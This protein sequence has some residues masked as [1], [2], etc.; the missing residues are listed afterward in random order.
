MRPG[1]AWCW[2]VLLL[3]PGAARRGLA[4]QTIINA[5]SIEQTP[6]GT[7]FYLH[8]SQVRAW[9]GRR[10]WLSTNFLTRGLTDRVEMA[11]TLYNAGSVVVP[12]TAA[13]TG[14][15]AAW[16]LDTASRWEPKL[17]GG[18]M[19]ILNLRGSGVGLWSYGLA[20]LRV[21]RLGLRLTGGPSAG[22]PQLFGR[23][24][25]HF[26]GTFEQP[27]AGHVSLIGEWWSGRHELGD[28]VPG[29]NWHSKRFVVVVGYKLSNAPG[30]ASDA[31]IVEAGVFF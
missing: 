9:D 19:L 18:Q 15:K 22:P 2:L 13:G 29:L 10:F 30:T 23:A 12:T 17:G 28:F 25:V 6:R 20:S 24:T 1:P 7:M 31:L 4:Q 14:W 8:E 26:I 11:L 21:P 27:L 5:P 3:C 16:P